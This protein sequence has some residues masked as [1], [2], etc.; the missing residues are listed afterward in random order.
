MK[1][2]QIVEQSDKELEQ[3]LKTSRES[4]AEAMVQLRTQKVP[5]VKQIAGIK[6][7]I[8]RVQTIERQRALT[9]ASTKISKTET[10]IDAKAPQ[11][12]SK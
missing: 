5:N 10:T 2:A 12:G 6:K 11:K 7:T 4:L 3:L 8:A 9:A 1:L